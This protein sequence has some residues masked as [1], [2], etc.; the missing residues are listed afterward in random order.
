VNEDWEGEELVDIE[1]PSLPV[2]LREHAGR[3]KNPG[4]VVIV[5]GNVNM[6]YRL[7]PLRFFMIELAAFQSN[8]DIA[9]PIIRDFPG[10]AQVYSSYF[11]P[12]GKFSDRR[13]HGPE[14]S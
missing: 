12:T 10:I 4:K 14:C 3:F 5:V 1:D 6:F 13:S 8:R 7:T 9:L 11:L 2:A